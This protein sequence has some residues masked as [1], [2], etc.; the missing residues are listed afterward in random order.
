MTMPPL[1]FRSTTLHQLPRTHSGSGRRAV[2]RAWRILILGGAALII[3]S[4]IL[5]V[6]LRVLPPGLDVLYQ[7][8]DEVYL[9]IKGEAYYR[10]F[11]GSD[12]FWRTILA[13]T[14]LIWV[15][16]MFDLDALKWAQNWTWQRL[17]R[18]PQRHNTAR[19]L[20]R[21][22]RRLG[23]KPTVARSVAI[24]A[25]ESALLD[26]SASDLHNASSKQVQTVVAL[27]A[28]HIEIE[29]ENYSNDYNNQRN[30]QAASRFALRI[31]ERW[32]RAL[33]LIHAYSATTNRHRAME[34]LFALQAQLP[35]DALNVTSQPDQMMAAFVQLLS[36]PVTSDFDEAPAQLRKQLGIPYREDAGWV[37]LDDRD[38]YA[39][40]L[41]LAEL[42]TI[43]GV[44]KWLHEQ[45]RTALDM[46]D[47]AHWLDEQHNIRL[48][49]AIAAL[50]HLLERRRVL[51]NHAVGALQHT[52][53]RPTSPHL[54]ATDTLPPPRLPALTVEDVPALH[55][56]SRIALNN[57]LHLTH[58]TRAYHLALG[59]IETLESLR[60]MVDMAPPRWL[61]RQGVLTGYL[62]LLDIAPPQPPTTSRRLTSWLQR[63]QAVI[64]LAF[65]SRHVSETPYPYLMLDDAYRLI[66]LMQ[67]QHVGAHRHIW[68]NDLSR[69][70]TVL[71][72][73]D[74][75][76]VDQ[77]IRVRLLAAAM[78]TAEPA[79]GNAKATS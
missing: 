32:Q 50:G 57:T 75:D 25:V 60:L 33:L 67:Q 6:H 71:Q 46:P 2:R 74:Y 39:P 72:R 4:L 8:H 68:E 1:K 23:M 26:L 78:H 43:I 64:Q 21:W 27:L 70:L 79:T 9:A 20:M 56:L 58:I 14:L 5:G 24:W 69:E 16:V 52:L 41:V 28:L 73:S 29:T 51:L 54:P 42:H 77:D 38:L 49:D 17:I 63:V 61:S 55:G 19:R 40:R 45:K 48:M 18:N 37:M 12:L 47:Y 44:L 36:D 13:L 11:P 66:A 10:V 62:A 22:G 65:G 15:L 31:L 59:H 7:V 76:G 53:V 3:F 35:L 34:A 30:K